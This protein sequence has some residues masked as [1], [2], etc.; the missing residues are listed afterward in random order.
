MPKKYLPEVTM[1]P[2][3]E[4]EP[5]PEPVALSLEF[6][7]EIQETITEEPPSPVKRKKLK[8]SDVFKPI[9]KNKGEN[10][11]V[12]R[13]IDDSQV[14]Q[15]K[16]II[17]LKQAAKKPKQKR[18]ATPAQLAALE[19]GRATRAANKKLRDAERAVEVEKQSETIAEK[20]TE[21][22]TEKIA[23]KPK[24]K[25]NPEATFT[26][27]DLAKASFH[28][29]EMYDERRKKRKAEKKKVTAI[30]QHEQKVF[31]D[32]NNA[33]GSSKTPDIYDNVFNF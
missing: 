9:L 26:R 32:I 33:L 4:P 1:P 17:P 11:L 7:E 16:D 8:K 19:K 24:E 5:E 22:V 6:E 25:R 14:L 15:A 27:E 18:T 31:K 2:A 3:P 28:A 10:N 30:K 20:V 23:A 13:E 21:K 29:V 12:I